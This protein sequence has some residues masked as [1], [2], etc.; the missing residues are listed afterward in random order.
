MT[1]LAVSRKEQ[2]H[3][4]LVHM[5]YVKAMATMATAARINLI[6]GTNV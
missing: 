5:V 4:Y 2:Y 1:L 6:A 3:A